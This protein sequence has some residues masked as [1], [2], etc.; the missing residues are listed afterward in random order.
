MLSAVLVALLDI[1][2]GAEP[3]AG[4]ALGMCWGGLVCLV[5]YLPPQYRLLDLS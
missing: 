3:G 5:E 2:P 4:V 1:A